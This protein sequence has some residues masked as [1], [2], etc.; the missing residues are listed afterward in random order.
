MGGD[1]VCGGGGAPVASRW[2]LVQVHGFVY[3]CHA[4]DSVCDT[5]A[6]FRCTSLI[7]LILSLIS[8]ILSCSITSF[9]IDGVRV[10]ST[11]QHENNTFLTTHN[12]AL[13]VCR[14]SHARTP[15]FLFVFGDSFCFE[16]ILAA[17]DF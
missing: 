2:A 13:S 5:T 17:T 15:L 8:S 6:P 9:G 14:S 11:R 10:S 16:A 4:A 7:S 12:T 1:V 3:L